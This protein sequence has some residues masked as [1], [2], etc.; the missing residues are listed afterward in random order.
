MPHTVD[1]KVFNI[2]RTEVDTNEVQKWMDFIGANEFFE[3]QFIDSGYI[4][5]KGNKIFDKPASNG[6]LLVALA[7]K[8]CYKSFQ[9]GMNPN[10][11][12]V[13]KDMCE[14]LDN[15]LASGHGSVLEHAVYSFAIENIS[16]VFTGEMNRHRAGWAISEGS[17]RYIRYDEIPYWLPTSLQVQEGDD[18]ELIDRKLGSQDIF[19]SI[20]TDIEQ[21]YKELCNLW[22]MDESDKNFK[23][24]KK[25]T[26]CLRRIIPMGIATGGVWT[27]NL[28]ALRHVIALRTEPA[29]EEEIFYVFCQIAKIML[30]KENLI[31]K[32]FEEDELTG[33][34]VPK[35]PK[36]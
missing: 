16:R 4:D 6:A 11:T 32:D 34:F 12:K 30:E 9:V 17:M 23:Y 31:F 7:A 27:G 18:P 26:S 28:R 22:Q 35:Y 25:I 36:V 2:A 13:R 33:S 10:I 19:N 3:E 24:K 1:I 14:Y 29:A 5:Q 8:R 21:A 15:V 20:F